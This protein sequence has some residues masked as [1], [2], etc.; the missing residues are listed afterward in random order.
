MEKVESVPC[1]FRTEAVGAFAQRC[2]SPSQGTA[3]NQGCAFRGAKLAL[4]PITDAAHL[5]HG[6]ITCQGHSWSVRPTA[7]SGSR[8]HRSTFIT[9]LGEMDIIYGGERKLAQAIDG[10]VSRHDPAAVFVYQTCL[11]AMIGDDIKAVCRTMSA[12]CGRPV[13]AVDAPG[14]AGGKDSGN[15]FAG[16]VLLDQVIGTREPDF[17][18]DYDIVLIGEYNVAGSVD[19]IRSLLGRLGIRILASIPGDGRYRDIASSHRAKASLTLCSRAMVDLGD[20]LQARFGIPGIAGSLYGLAQTSS[21]LRN[22]ATL[23]A[24]QTGK[25]AFIKQAQALIA[26]AETATWRF[27]APFKKRLQGKRA[28]LVA[29]GTKSWSLINA[30]EEIGLTVVGSTLQKTSADDRRRARE[31]AAARNIHLYENLGSHRLETLLLREE[32][33]VLLSGMGSSFAAA[34]A[35]IAWVDISH[36]RTSPLAGYEGVVRLAEEIDAACHNPVFAQARLPAPW[37]DEWLINAQ[38]A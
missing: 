6:P 28:L 16:Q 11:P 36:H 15:T 13:I 19:I 14:F 38:A 17:V 12:R 29:G 1:T 24:R 26:E 3:V 32:V 18:T 21:T 27:L 35:G 31:I 30:L 4:Q 9:D 20:R 37:E 22:L 5:V 25:S 23:L 2:F 34:R 10:I 8:L 7:S 33:D